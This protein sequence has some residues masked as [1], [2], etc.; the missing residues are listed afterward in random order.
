MGF[1]LTSLT[2]LATASAY[3]PITPN[4]HPPHPLSRRTTLL[5]SPKIL[6][7]LFSSPASG[8]DEGECLPDEYCV[9]NENT[10]KKIRLTTEEKERIYLD[11][12]QSYY[13][14]G[15]QLLSGEDFDL[16]KEDL[17]WGG[18]SV[19]TM[20][21]K[22]IQYTQAMQAFNKGE[23][24]MEDAAFDALKR[25]LK[26]EGS[27]FAVSKE[28]K[29]YIDTGVC[30]VTLQNDD[31][32]TN[33]LYLP[34]GIIA[35]SLWI[36]GSWQFIPALRLIN[37]LFIILLGSPLVYLLTPFITDNFLFENKKIAFGPCPQCEAENRVYFGNILG[38]EGF[39]ENAVVK[40]GNCKTEFNVQRSTL[41]AS[42]NP[43][44][45]SS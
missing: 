29:C 9:I 26:E 3:L 23:M 38:C 12:V 40:C 2:L 16:L 18:S 4:S 21:K 11:A 36:F 5:S 20:N 8:A 15:R 19:I 34:V 7:P 30:T 35:A 25:E 17:A 22:E 33:L 14:D 41:R 37:P 44:S 6:R 10:G 24:L 28:P 1:L 39:G 45:I 42:T 27:K 43:K 32:R 31:F 13:Y